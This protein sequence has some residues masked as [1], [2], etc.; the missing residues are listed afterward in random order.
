MIKE[1]NSNIPNYLK[2][3]GHDK[4]QKRNLS[5]LKNYVN[6][7][8]QIKPSS[9]DIQKISK[10]FNPS[11]NNTILGSSVKIV[12]SIEPAV[13]I[14]TRTLSSSKKSSPSKSTTKLTCKPFQGSKP[15][16]YKN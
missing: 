8:N 2:P 9:A 11:S 13:R 15:F 10:S 5:K 14:E 6:K 7:F 4:N 3:I 16:A 1:L 12:N